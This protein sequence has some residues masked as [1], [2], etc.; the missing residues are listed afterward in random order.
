MLKLVLPD[1]IAFRKF[2]VQ[3]YVEKNE[4]I[5]VDLRSILV[6]VKENDLQWKLSKYYRLNR[7]VTHAHKKNNTLYLWNDIHISSRGQKSDFYCMTFDLNQESEGEVIEFP[8]PRGSEF[9]YMKP[10]NAMDRTEHTIALSD[11]TDYH[12]RIYNADTSTCTILTR[13]PDQWHVIQDYIPLP[14]GEDAPQQY[15]P[16]MDSIRRTASLVT[17]VT[18]LNDSSLLVLWSAPGENDMPLYFA[19]I[20]E[21]LES[22]WQLVKSDIAVGY[23][24]EIESFTLTS[25]PFSPNYMYNDGKFIT[26]EHYPLNT[27]LGR[28]WQG[29]VEYQNAKYQYFTDNPLQ[30][31]AIIRRLVP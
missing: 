23:P 14:A 8:T 12:I 7:T 31:I 25:L 17:R 28:E 26:L 5:L 6:F 18:L 24:N 4:I 19:D 29:A 15:F 30:F 1:S 10:R 20:W 22:R 16:G 13:Q 27:P 9:M 3:F 21:R 11:I 2:V